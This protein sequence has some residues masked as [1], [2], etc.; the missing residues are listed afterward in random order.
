[1]G[2]TINEKLKALDYMTL[3]QDTLNLMRECCET[4]AKNTGHIVFAAGPAVRMN[5]DDN[6]SISGICY[7]I[8]VVHSTKSGIKN[9]TTGKV[10][11]GVQEHYRRFWLQKDGN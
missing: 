10:I 11:E 5:D 7:R 8:R 3:Y 9:K 1:M 2:D 4:L 6:E